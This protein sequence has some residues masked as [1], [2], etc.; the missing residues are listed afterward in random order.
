MQY[1]RLSWIDTTAT[2]DDAFAPPAQAGQSFEL[3][4][5]ANAVHDYVLG[6]VSRGWVF[7]HRIAAFASMTHILQVGSPEFQISLAY[8]LASGF[9]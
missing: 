4:N 2:L 3:R 1:E 8:C 7:T 6:S 5:M 9:R